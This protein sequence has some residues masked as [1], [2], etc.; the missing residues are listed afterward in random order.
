MCVFWQVG[1]AAHDE[2]ERDPIGSGS[3]TE[4]VSTMLKAVVKGSAAILTAIGK[5]VLC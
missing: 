4:G 3:V 5:A 2:G 1:I